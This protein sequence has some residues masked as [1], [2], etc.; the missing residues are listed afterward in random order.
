MSKE[1]KTTVVSYEDFT[2]IDFEPPSTFFYKNAL[3]EM[4]FIHTSKREVAQDYVDEV[5]GVKGKYRVVA[6]KIQKG[7]GRELTCTGV[8]T[9]KG[10][11]KY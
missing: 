4:I 8:A 2:S 5:T 10:Q 7:N 11:K 6:S 9:K 1:L 3:G